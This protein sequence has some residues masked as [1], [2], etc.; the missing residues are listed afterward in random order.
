MR[1][2]RF[3]FTTRL[4]LVLFMLSAVPSLALLGLATWGL[5]NYVEL[6]GSA[7]PWGQV[8]STGGELLD[9]VDEA[10]SDSI[11]QAAAE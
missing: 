8:A 5:R 6:A 4:F 11:V 3:S 2:R 10:A 1:R 9:A 7:G